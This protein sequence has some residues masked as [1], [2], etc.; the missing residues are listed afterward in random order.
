MGTYRLRSSVRGRCWMRAQERRR[1]V[2]GHASQCLC[3][4]AAWQGQEETDGGLHGRRRRPVMGSPVHKTSARTR[5][6][7]A[8]QPEA[9]LALP[10]LAWR[11]LHAQWSDAGAL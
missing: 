5:A 1:S 6:Q 10:W 2:H 4:A 8:Q 7:R 11:R 9:T 3:V